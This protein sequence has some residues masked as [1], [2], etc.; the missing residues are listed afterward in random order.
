MDDTSI[1]M[2]AKCKNCEHNKLDHIISKKEDKVS[3]VG[4]CCIQGC[5]C[6]H[7]VNKEL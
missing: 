3:R 4:V 5:E 6:K 7:F 1:E 2:Y